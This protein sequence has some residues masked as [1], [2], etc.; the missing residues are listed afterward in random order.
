MEELIRG[1]LSKRNV[2]DLGKELLKELNVLPTDDAM[3]CIV[4]RAAKKMDADWLEEY[5]KTKDGKETYYYL[6]MIN[7]TL[8]E[9]ITASV[10]FFFYQL[11]HDVT[12]SFNF[13]LMEGFLKLRKYLD[14]TIKAYEGQI[15]IANH[16]LFKLYLLE[17]EWRKIHP[18]V[19]LNDSEKI[20]AFYA[21][22]KS[23]EV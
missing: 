14:N 10:C 13:D 22:K 23:L 18:R 9:G 21:K 17:E 4:L 2:D 6:Q 5:K 15:T 11:T 7:D 12:R 20:Q 16:P 3:D 8:S 19:S 1:T